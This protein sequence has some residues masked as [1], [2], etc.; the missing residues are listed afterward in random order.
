MRPFPHRYTA[1]ASASPTGDVRADSPGLPALATAAP[2]A[3]GGPGGRWSPE[4]LLTAAVADCFILTFR[5]V[6]AASALPWTA[7]ECT[8]EGT[9]DRAERVTRFTAFSVRAALRV[10]GG[11][12]PDRARR[13]LERAERLCLITASLHAPTHLKADVRVDEAVAA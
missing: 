3:F 6:A 11:T 4:T 7:L 2:E 13:L 10:P 8:A 12:D 5:A 1:T 9:L